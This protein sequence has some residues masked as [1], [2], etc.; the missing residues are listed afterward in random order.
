MIV[1]GLTGGI[2]TGKSTV[3]AYLTRLGA[4]VLDADKIAHTVY[5]KGLPAWQEII[6]H[7]GKTVLLPG[8][9]IDRQK[10]GQL[11]FRQPEVLKELN[12]IVHPHVKQEMDRLLQRVAEKTPRAVAILD[13]PLLFETGMNKGL[14]EV[15]V[16]YTPHEIQLKRLIERDGLNR[17]DATARINAQMSIEEKKQLATLVIDN[18]GP[19]S[20]TRHRTHE[21]YEKIRA[22]YGIG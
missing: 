1:A 18:S 7:F 16:V 8:G 11:V 10:L 2:A 12:A 5:R 15:I 20:E 19:L 17:K 21:I 14:A 9:E 4:A 13:V 6:D 22:K 3:S